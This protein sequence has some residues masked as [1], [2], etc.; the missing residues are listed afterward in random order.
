MSGHAAVLQMD[1]LQ[2][3]LQQQEQRAEELLKASAEHDAVR[4]ARGFCQVMLQN[5]HAL[6]EAHHLVRR[7]ACCLAR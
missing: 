7:I 1:K 4:Q 2:Q 6:C 3:Q 5:V